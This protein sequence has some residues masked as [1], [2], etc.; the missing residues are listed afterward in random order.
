M[1]RS[2]WTHEVESPKFFL[3]KRS[4]IISHDNK[5][6]VF[7][8]SCWIIFSVKFWSRREDFI[9][10]PLILDLSIT[11]F[12]TKYIS[13][14]TEPVSKLLSTFIIENTL[15]LSP[16]VVYSSISVLMLLSSV[17]RMVLAASSPRYITMSTPRLLICCLS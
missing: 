13:S 12:K 2:I 5:I 15:F 14:Y 10:S 9:C 7:S 8:E 4:F 17:S 11:I 1:H 6:P 16:L 3:F